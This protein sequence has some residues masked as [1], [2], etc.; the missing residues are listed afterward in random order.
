MTAA[1]MCA[2]LGLEPTALQ[3]KVEQ[4]CLLEMLEQGDLE[5]VERAA[6]SC[7]GG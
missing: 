3:Q 2:H 4:C 7:R 5:E 6:Y 1:Q